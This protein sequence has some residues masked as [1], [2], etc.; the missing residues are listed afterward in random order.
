[1][2]TIKRFK[3]ISIK[4]FLLVF[5]S[6]AVCG[7]FIG[8]AQA[9]FYPDRP[10]YDYSKE[11]DTTDNDP[12]DRCG[13]LNGPVFNSFVNTPSYGDERMFLDAR[14]SDQTSEGSYK[15]VLPDVTDGSKE[16]V[17]R[18]YVHNNANQT[19]NA[20]GAGIAKNT[21]VKIL[22]PTAE[23]N[24][25]R[26]RGYISADNAAMV[27]D[28]VDLS[29]TEDFKVEYV[30]GS[31]KL[32][33]NGPFKD[34]VALSDEV[35]GGGALVGYDKLDGN[36]PGCFDY[37]T[38]VQITVKITPKTTEERTVDF[39]KKVRI[40]GE[41]E[42]RSEVTTKPG[43]RLEWLLA[44]DFMHSQ[45]QDNITL[46]DVQVPNNQLVSGSVQ[47][48]D[49][50]DGTK[51][52][53]DAPLFDSGFNYGSYATGSN[54]FVKYETTVLDN[55]TECEVRVRNLAYYKSTQQTAEKEAYADA[56]IKKPSCGPV[57]TP[58]Y[59]CE[60]FTL[61]KNAVKINEKFSAK[62]KVNAQNGAQFKQATFTFG[63]EAANGSKFLTNVVTDG[64]VTA[65]H[66]YA[67]EGDYAPR[68][69][70]E[71]TVNGETKTV[72]DAKCVAQIKVTKEQVLAVTTPTTLPKTGASEVAGIFSV[73]TVA[74]AAL[75]R[76]STIKKRS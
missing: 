41:S 34:G 23:G 15:N 27:E 74:G 21:K 12:N 71:F 76:R 44:P 59:T 60:S 25:L 19:T 9:E 11:C 7:I 56:V 52:Q 8:A 6:V 46:R 45:T 32:Y 10:V 70:L 69:K 1:M 39:S 73:V 20:S 5:A 65:E 26:A 24:A 43:D 29:A 67:K 28:T 51:V 48:I 66:A 16:V 58:S 14:R 22:L 57:T 53:E 3:K 64:V 30:V 31:A 50:S 72:E 2:N 18:T 35:V 63:D 62:V 13:S 42:W 37:Q 55:F 54:F 33:N 4:S 49:A 40:K 36:L 17:I 68:V 47:W 61:S 75:H 38:V